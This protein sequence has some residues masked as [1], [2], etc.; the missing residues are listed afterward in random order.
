MFAVAGFGYA[1]ASARED[2]AAG[3]R[4]AEAAVSALESGDF[5]RARADFAAA[6]VVLER[7]HADLDSP[8]AAA[9]S[10]VPVLAQ[11]REAAVGMSEA[12]FTGA[13][14]V[15]AAIDEI[16]LEELRVVGGRIDVAAIAALRMPFTRVHDALDRLGSAVDEARSPWLVNRARIELDDFELSVA[17]HLPSLENAIAATELAPDMLGSERQQTYLVLFTTPS[18]ARGLGGFVGNYAELTRR[19]R[20]ALPE[21][22]R[23]RPRTL[24]R[25]VAAAG[26]ALDGPAGFLDRYAPFGFVDDGSGSSATPRS[27][28]SR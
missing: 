24:D 6:A 15:A 2:L 25:P 10:V 18:E 12:G 8:L 13:A 4:Y 22:V 20:P 27:A 14:D 23:A 9:A 1:A 7:A 19:R 16:D 21:R 5:D 3:V 26:V 17:E 28:T 11:H